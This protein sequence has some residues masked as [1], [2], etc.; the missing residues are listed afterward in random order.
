MVKDSMNILFITSG[1]IG[2]AVISTGLLVYLMETYPLARFTIAVGPAAAPLFEAFPKLDKLIVLR[3]QSWNRHWL[4]FWRQVR[5]KRWDMVVDLRAGLAAHLLAAKVR[6]VFRKPDKSLSKATQLAALFNLT[7]LPPTQLWASQN[8]RSKARDLVPDYPFIVM[9]PKT[10]S[11]VKDWPIEHFATL[12]QRLCA[13][14]KALVILASAEQR[15]RVQLLAQ[16]LPESRVFNLSGQ[17]DLPTAYA[18][19]ERAQLFVGNDSGL[20]HMAAAAKIPCVGIYGPSND[21]IYA[22]QGAHVRI[23]TAREFAPDE[24]EIRGDENIIRRISIGKVQ[25]AIAALGFAF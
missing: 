5:G 23:V 13:N 4:D 22:P 16:A 11:H 21:K 14:D 1:S 19:L 7:S 8:A 17:T 15:D 25:E 24:P 18:L 3:K 2:D 10:N 6:K 20:L 12:A 9:A